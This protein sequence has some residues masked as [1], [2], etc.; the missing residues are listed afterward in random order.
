[1]PPVNGI[2]ATVAAGVPV[3]VVEEDDVP[4]AAPDGV[5]DGVV[6]PDD[7]PLG[8]RAPVPV[9]EGVTVLADVT[10]ADE[11]GVGE[12]P[13]G[14]VTDGD[15]VPLAVIDELADDVRDGV[16]VP[17]EVADALADAGTNATL[18]YSTLADEGPRIE[19]HTF[20]NVS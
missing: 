7:E 11:E 14:R 17:V 19:L 1:M 20:V 3:G 13:N 15:A 10:D 5:F 2:G 4:V 16:C 9:V 12:D 6:V 8:V 18:R